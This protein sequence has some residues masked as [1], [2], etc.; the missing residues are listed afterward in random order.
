MNDWKAKEA[1]RA[2]AADALRAANPHLVSCAGI[3]ARV[4]AAKN[5]R[6]ELARAFPGIKFSVKGRSFSG[7]DAIDVRWTDGPVSAQVDA[8]IGRYA[9]GSFNGMDDL[10]T[11]AHSAWCDA[12][13]DAQ[14]V[15]AN[16][17]SSDRAIA[18]A[19]RYVAAKYAGNFAARGIAAPSIADYRAGKCWGVQVMDGDY[20][21]R[22]E[23]QALISEELYRR[24]WAIDRTPRAAAMADDGVAA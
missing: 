16:R 21:Q 1:A 4:A 11:Y 5:I 12:F 2:S 10:Y 24:C 17:D 15:H 7:G 6:I 14:Y 13:G 3:G 18:S 23:L 20:C 8:I 19:I 22:W 9:A